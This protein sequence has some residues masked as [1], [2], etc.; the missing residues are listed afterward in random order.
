MAIV[1]I[2]LNLLV[3]FNQLR[4]YSIIIIEKFI[5]VHFAEVVLT[6]FDVQHKVHYLWPTFIWI[7]TMHFTWRR[8]KKRRENGND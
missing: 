1:Q 7:H 6:S 2:H 5:K 3:I 4:L 8:E